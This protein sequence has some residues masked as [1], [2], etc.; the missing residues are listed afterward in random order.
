MPNRS[1][2][3]GADP[4]PPPHMGED[5]RR[6]SGEDL[7]SGLRD[8]LLHGILVRLRCARSAERTS[9]LSRRWRHVWSHMPELLLD[10]SPDTVDG[11]LAGYLAPALGR[12]AISLRADPNDRVLAER[13][14]PWLR[15]AA[16]R[17][18]GELRICY[19]LP[20]PLDLVLPM[21]KADFEL[22]VCGG[23]Q[24]ITLSLGVAW[25][26]RLRPGGL[27]SA[28][29]E[30]NIHRAHIEA[31]TLCPRL[32]DLNL[33]VTLIAA[34]NVT[35]RSDSLRSLRF[36]VLNT[37]QLELF[38]PRLEKL[39]LSP[40]IG[41]HISAPKL[42]QLVFLFANVYDPRNHHFLDVGRALPPPLLSFAELELQTPAD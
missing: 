11:A 21:E 10:K 38:V 16:E 35:I 4:L 31:I 36:T 8:E 9:V 42:A 32:S 37:Q 18:A 33:N 28:L 2:Q 19:V 5:R 22:P 20:R 29:S 7:I 25:Q 1:G 17:V 39:A 12:L 34:S 13:A 27:F 40:S 41:A 30:L 26:L 14:A 15:F 3:Q 24:R 6:R 23:V